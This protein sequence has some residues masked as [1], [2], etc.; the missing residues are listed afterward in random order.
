VTS[1]RTLCTGRVID[2]ELCYP[3]KVLN[4]IY[5]LFAIR[6]NNFREIYG[7]RMSKA[8][9]FMIMDALTLV[10]EPMGISAAVCDPA[11][12]IRLDDNITR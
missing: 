3:L 10:D 11:S 5:Q 6:A 1:H 4:T 9:E 2:G 12:F 7:H 8:I